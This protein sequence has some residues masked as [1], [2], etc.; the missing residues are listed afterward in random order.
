[1]STSSSRIFKAPTAK[2]VGT[3]ALW[4]LVSTGAAHAQSCVEQSDAATTCRLVL[5][6]ASAFTIQAKARLVGRL[7][8]GAQMTIV[9]NGQPCRGSWHAFW[10]VA[11]KECRV[12]FPATTSVVD[13]SIAGQG[14]HTTGVKIRLISNGRLAALPQEA[15]DLYP[16]R[17]GGGLWSN[18]WP[19]PIR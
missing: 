16:K 3:A 7:P 12:Q 19:F 17:R 5:S 13:A 8:P 1:M 18:F 10:G 6:Q 15:G 4:V 14:V 2:C 9:V 11:S